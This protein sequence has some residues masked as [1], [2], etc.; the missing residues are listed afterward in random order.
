MVTN[1]A[2]RIIE[3]LKN[4]GPVPAKDLTEYFE[5]SRQALFKHLAKLLL[6]GKIAK[7]GRPPQVFY[8]IKHAQVPSD[9]RAVKPESE[10]IIKKNYLLITPSGQK[11][12]G[13]AGFIYWCEKNRLDIAKTA[14]QYVATLAK[15]NRYKHKGFIDGL[16]KLKSTF[17][18]IFLDSLFY[19]DFYSIERFG[20]T[21]LGQ[22]LLY[23]KQS[24]NK[25]L[26]KQLVAEIAQEIKLIISKFNIEAVGFIPPTVKRE[27]QFMKELQKYLHLAQPALKLV[28]IKTPIAVPQKSLGKLED[29]VENASATIFPEEK[30]RFGNILLID[31][32][33]GSGATMNETAKKI[34]EQKICEGKLLGLAITGSFKGFDIISEI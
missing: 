11:L 8:H 33:V 6:A 1:T 21:R 24:Q 29:R 20:K 32:A 18:E 7:V 23:A 31:D 27:V 16:P 10:R 19:L 15:F 2:K 12:E 30:R 26:I 34:R 13:M 5:I 28:K 25:Q 22:M 3:Y 17:K 4:R 9:T 14:E